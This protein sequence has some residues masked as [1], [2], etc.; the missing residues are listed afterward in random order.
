MPVRSFIAVKILETNVLSRIE[1][2]Q[3]R[4]TS[5]G[6]RIKLV[7]P[8]NIHLTMK[9]LGDVSEEHIEDVKKGITEISFKPFIMSLEN[10]GVFPNL[11]RPR[12]IWAGINQGVDSL[13][14]IHKTIDSRLSELGFQKDNRKFN[15][16]VTIG[17][18]RS[19]QN[20]DA[21]VRCLMNNA[22][23][24]FGEILV[25]RIFLMK[26]ILTNRGPIY[27]NL[28]VSIPC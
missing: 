24:S 13:T 16:H 27:S 26:S 9:F 4:L 2:I 12:T 14:S 21:F 1:D 22:N 23:I 15:P 8:E 18:V 20:I 17:R 5:T 10:V 3:N 11:K 19:L 25:D 6:A 7:E 28:A